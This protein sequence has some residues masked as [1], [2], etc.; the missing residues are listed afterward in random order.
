MKTPMKIGIVAALAVAVGVVIAVKYTGGTRGPSDR[1][2]AGEGSGLPT[3][4]ES[5][6]DCIPC[7]IMRATL[8]QLQA[9]CAGR[10]RV[11]FVDYDAGRAVVNR[12]NVRVPCT[13]I[14]LDASGVER[15]RHTGILSAE[16]ILAK[17]KELGVDVAARAGGGTQPAPPAATQTDAPG[18]GEPLF[19]Q[20]GAGPWRHERIL[21]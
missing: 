18:L 15:F 6:A 9:D 4:I 2:P 21:R 3:I 17:W 12:Y 14:F 1:Q 19:G 5:G 16:E 13:Q 7:Q 8:E 20:T 11:Q 10:L